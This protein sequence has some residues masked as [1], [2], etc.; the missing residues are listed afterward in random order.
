[1]VGLI[2]VSRKSAQEQENMTQSKEDWQVYKG[3]GKEGKN[4]VKIP[5]A[6]PWPDQNSDYKEYY[7]SI[8]Q[9]SIPEKNKGKKYRAEPKEIQMVNMALNLRR[10]LLVTGKPG[11]GKSSLAYSIAYEL[12]L[13]S[14][15]RWNITSRTMLKD[16]L[17]SYDAIGRLQESNIN[18]GETPPSI[19]DY[20]RLGSLGTALLPTPKPRVLLIDEIDKCDIDLPN[21]LLNIFEEGK[22]DI[23]ELVRLQ[24][25]DES[26]HVLPA[27]SDTKVPIIKG[28]IYCREFPLVIL[29]S[30]GERDFPPAFLR[31]CLRLDL[32]NPADKT[33]FADKLTKIV[34]AHL[35]DLD[36]GIVSKIVTQFIEKGRDGTLA[37][38]QLLNAIF[39]VS[40]LQSTDQAV[41]EELKQELIDK[42]LQPLE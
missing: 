37:N 19:G 14:V 12:N 36:Q 23:P 8:K 33:K 34:N 38:D 6:P 5:E 11:I 13:G 27:D 41:N 22:F 25:S 2:V 17:Y 29:T 24:K 28:Q 35:S 9:L 31:R 30:N 42:L 18:P 40:K 39:L 32:A 16:G 3:T 21:D 10:P 15:L 1:M 20:I 26:I 7:S 4:E